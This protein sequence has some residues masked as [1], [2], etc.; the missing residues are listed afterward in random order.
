M[1]SR[2]EAFESPITGK[3]ITSWRDR[4]RD[5]DAAGAVDPRD[6]PRKPFEQR[7]KKRHERSIIEAAAAIAS[8]S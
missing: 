5:M 3:E 8:D 2:I 1:I 4:D 6:L 7:K